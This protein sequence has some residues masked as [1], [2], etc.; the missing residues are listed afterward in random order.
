MGKP[1]VS[2]TAVEQ[3]SDWRW[4]L[5]NLYFITDESGA[6]IQFRMNWAQEQLFE[7]M[8]YLNLVL[9]ARQLGFTTFIQLFML[10]AC[11]FNSN[12]RAGVIAHKM[13]AAEA[14]FRDKIKFPYD[15]LP[16]ALRAAVPIVKDNTTTLELSNNSLISVGTS[17]RSGTLQYLHVSEFGKVCAKYPDKAREIV[18]GALN[19]K[20]PAAAN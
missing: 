20:K 14:I 19:R 17:M 11:I 18:T 4:R 7:E 12:I 13:D 2:R 9:K 5:N 3:F 8:H 6:K 16:S 1:A 15:N 10:D